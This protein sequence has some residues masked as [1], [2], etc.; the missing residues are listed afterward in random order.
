[1]SAMLTTVWNYVAALVTGIPAGA[2]R[3]ET[4][5]EKLTLIGFGLNPRAEGE[6]WARCIDRRAF[7][8]TPYVALLRALGG[9][10]D[11]LTDAMN[12]EAYAAFEASGQLEGE[13]FCERLALVTLD[14]IVCPGEFG[15]MLRRAATILGGGFD[16]QD[17]RES[18]A[19][20][21]DDGE[22]V[23]APR[24]E[25]T[26]TLDGA[27]HTWTFA[28]PVELICADLLSKLRE[29]TDAGPGPRRLYMIEFP[30]ETATAEFDCLDALLIGATTREISD[31]EQLLGYRVDRFGAPRKLLHAASTG[32]AA[33]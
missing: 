7:A 11:A 12:F 3:Y 13:F 31:L 4:Q 2:V 9:S 10:D 21:D 25:L 32:P 30:D 20:V 17:I 27:N 19:L 5:L 16:P 1:M 18:A 6:E 28:G 26:F 24:A 22:V 14:D 29:I 8:R 23:E 15:R 33:S